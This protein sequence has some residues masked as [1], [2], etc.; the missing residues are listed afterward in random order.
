MVN[1]VPPF[2]MNRLE[3]CTV[4]RS[5]LRS[6]HRALFILLLPLSKPI[7]TS[8]SDVHFSGA[9]TYQLTTNEREGIFHEYE[10]NYHT[11]PNTD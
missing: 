5:D 2:P 8:L 1:R 10:L 7:Q 9:S 11:S 6:V 3:S 4:Y